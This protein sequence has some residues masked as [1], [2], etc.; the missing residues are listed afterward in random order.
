MCP[1][2]D[3][4][5]LISQRS[6]AVSSVTLRSPVRSSFSESFNI[7]KPWKGSGDYA[8]FAADPGIQVRVSVRPQPLVPLLAKLLPQL[9]WTE[10]ARRTLATARA[11]AHDAPSLVAVV[12]A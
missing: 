2:K 8:N 6:S 1:S 9:R 10:P 12:A 11:I 4:V 3:N 5:S 7:S